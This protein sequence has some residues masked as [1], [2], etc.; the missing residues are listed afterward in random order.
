M[1]AAICILKLI[2]TN[3]SSGPPRHGPAA[4]STSFVA[5]M[6]SYSVSTGG[7][8]ASENSDSACYAAQSLL[9]N[10]VGLYH[11]GPASISET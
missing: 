6:S 4:S 2:K 3:S 11:E 9:A 1:E 7:D 10:T 8:G 5:G